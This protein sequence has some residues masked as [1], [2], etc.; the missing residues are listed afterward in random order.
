MSAKFAL[1]IPTVPAAEVSAKSD[2][3]RD[4]M[5]ARGSNKDIRRPLDALTLPDDSYA[6]IS[7]LSGGR[8]K[9]TSVASG[10]SSSNA[11]ILI[12]SLSYAVTEKHQ[13][14][15]T[16]DRDRL[17]FFGQ[18]LPS[19]NISAKTLDTLTFQWLQEIYENYATRLGG[20]ISAEK[21]A[22][23]QITSD[24]RVYTGYILDLKFTKTA[25]DR[26]MADVSFT[27]ALTHLKH[28]KRLRSKVNAKDLGQIAI[29]DA[30]QGVSDILKQSDGSEASAETP[31]AAQTDSDQGASSLLSA[32][33]YAFKDIYINEYPNRSYGTLN[34][35]SFVVDSVTPD[36]VALDFDAGEVQST[37]DEI[38]EFESTH[39]VGITELK[40][41]RE[42]V[43]MEDVE[44][45]F[46]R[47]TPAVAAP[48][49]LETNNID[50]SIPR[51]GAL[52]DFPESS[53]M[54]F[55]V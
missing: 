51:D 29:E 10:T 45:P 26:Y 44:A 39:G 52:G 9:N 20:S 19:L 17:F 5:G 3:L 1:I 43:S 27:M 35:R 24:D 37:F 16:F 50:D 53:A 23:V 8:L 55:A 54:S 7:L 13:R 48:D 2:E 41:D 4:E 11:N 18:A 40:T 32:D 33:S 38:V 28:L 30:L 47:P 15:Q 14:A 36:K 42:G 21:G 6:T 22:K 46:V 49:V 12:Q 25:Q 34:Q 31:L